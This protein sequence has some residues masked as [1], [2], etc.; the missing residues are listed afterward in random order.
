MVKRLTWQRRVRDLLNAG[1]CQYDI[2]AFIGCSQS[3]ISHLNT[4]KRK[5]VTGDT[6]L[7]LDRLHFS[8]MTE[9]QFPPK[10]QK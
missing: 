1:F 2:A 6:A 4:G 5:S 10:E 9:K 3:T 8:V 7:R